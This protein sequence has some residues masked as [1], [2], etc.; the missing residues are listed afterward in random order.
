VK[1]VELVADALRGCSGRGEIVLDAF[2]GSGTTL[3]AAERTGQLSRPRTRSGLCR[4]RDPPLAGADRRASPSCRERSAVR[5]KPPGIGS[6]GMS[7]DMPNYQVGYGKP[8]RHTRFQKGRSGNPR[9]RPKGVQSF[10]RLANQVFNEKIAPP[11]HG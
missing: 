5:R 10:A 8:P 6:G 9:G 1:P 7:Q 3:I 2:L 4:Y 11:H